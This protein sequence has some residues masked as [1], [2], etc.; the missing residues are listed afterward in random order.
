M[1]AICALLIGSFVAAVISGSAGFGGA[2]LL[3]PLLNQAV[4][5]TL[6]VPLL[7]IAQLVGNLSRVAFGWREIRWRPVL[8]FLAPALPAAALGAWWFTALPKA[9]TV[10]CLGAAILLFV[11]LKLRGLNFRPSPQ[12]LICGGAVVGLLSGL[13][14]SAGLI[15]AAIFLSLDLP[16]VAYVASEATTAVAMHLVKWAVYQRVIVLD[17][18]FWSLAAGMSVA[19]VAGTWVGKRL[20]ETLSVARFRLLVAGLLAVTAVQMLWMG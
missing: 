16:P 13:V 5:V 10:R 18:A 9:L 4:G 8:L 20:I 7:T 11:I 19:M 14:G 12:L 15:G 17:G 2:L 1:L 3:L 6:A